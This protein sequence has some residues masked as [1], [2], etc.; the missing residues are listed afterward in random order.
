MADIVLLAAGL[1][2]LA[3]RAK[4]ARSVRADPAHVTGIRHVHVGTD[5]ENGLVTNTDR[6]ALRVDAHPPGFTPNSEVIF[7]KAHSMIRASA[8]G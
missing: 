8:C 3:F 4:R 6:D 1:C 5:E 7:D 2:G